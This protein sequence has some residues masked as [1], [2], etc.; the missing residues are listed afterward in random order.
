MAAGLAVVAT[1]IG[2]ARHVVGDAGIIVR[3]RDPEALAAALKR[4]IEAPEARARLGALG[5]RRVENLF[6]LE[7]ALVGFE[8]AYLGVE[9]PAA[10]VA[11]AAPES[12]SE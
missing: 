1:D 9:P 6:S 3:P 8:N 4:L 10:P 12:G 11:T 2:D 7:S 5:R